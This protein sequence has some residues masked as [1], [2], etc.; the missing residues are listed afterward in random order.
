[1]EVPYLCLMLKLEMPVVQELLSREEIQMPE[2]PFDSPAMATAETTV[3]FLSACCR[4]VDLLDTPQDIPFVG[5]LIQ[6]E[7]I[8]RI[9]RGPEGARLRAIGTLGDQSQ[10]TAKAIAWIR[11]NHAKRLRVWA[12]PRCTIVSGR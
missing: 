2:A 11:A 10:R 4:L 12:S 6:R 3:E 7:I 1:V 5:G 9:L 8:Y